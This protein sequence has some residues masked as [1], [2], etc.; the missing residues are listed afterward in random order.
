MDADP[1]RRHGR[2]SGLALQREG[3]DAHS[4]A[5]PSY[6]PPAARPL[7]NVDGA[8]LDASEDVT[9]VQPVAESMSTADTVDASTAIAATAPLGTKIEVSA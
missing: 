1:G 3:V 2:V 4:A 5:T 9:F 8:V 6:W 7:R